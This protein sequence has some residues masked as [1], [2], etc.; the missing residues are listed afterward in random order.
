MYKIVVY[1][2]LIHAE[3]VKEA[4][5]EGGAGQIG[6]YQRCCWETEGMGQFEPITGS[7]P[8][9]GA[10]GKQEKVK[11]IKVELVCK[12]QYL[13][14]ALQAMLKAHPYEEPAYQVMPFL[15]IEDIE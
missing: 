8:F 10:L 7:N 14:S 13:K 15:T 11:E 1:I 9:I 6:Q 2:P 3:A 4:L 12:K 5:F